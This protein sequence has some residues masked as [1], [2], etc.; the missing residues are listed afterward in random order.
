MCASEEV[1]SI[2]IMPSISVIGLAESLSLMAFDNIL[3]DASLWGTRIV[4]K[5]KDAINENS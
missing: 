3:F 5:Y 2:Y 4:L 1:V